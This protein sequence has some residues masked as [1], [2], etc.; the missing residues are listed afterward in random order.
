[1]NAQLAADKEQRVRHI[2]PIADKSQLLALDLVPLFPQRQHVAQHLAG[3]AK[4][5]QAI[6]HRHAGIGRQFLDVVMVKDAR[7]DALHV[8]REDARHVGH[9]FALAQPDLGGRE[10][11]RVPAQVGH[12]HVKG[13][14]GAQAGLFKDQGQ[15]LAGQDRLVAA[16]F[17]LGLEFARGIQNLPDFV[18]AQIGH[19]QKMLHCALP[20]TSFLVYQTWRAM[21][22]AQR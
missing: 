1:M 21:E 19:A 20:P 9:G 11:D 5:G 14:A 18:R 4:V 17:P 10:I 2:V 16:R 15:R 7:L 13:D 22:S 6:D 8:S 3:M 12:R